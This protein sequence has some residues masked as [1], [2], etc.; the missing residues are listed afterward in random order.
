MHGFN[1]RVLG[2]KTREE[3]RTDQCQVAQQERDPSD[4]HVFTHTTH[5]AN[6]LVVV[7]T[8]DHRASPEEQQRFE[9]RVCHQVE[10]GYGVGRHTQRNRHITQLR[11]RGV[12][13]HALDVVLDDAQ[14][15]HEQ[16][17]DGTDHQNEVQCHIRQFIQGRHARHHK[18]TRRH[19]GRRVDQCGDR[20]GAFHGIWQPSMQRELRRLTHGTNEQA[21]GGHRD[22]RP[23]GARQSLRGKFW[24]LGKD[25]SVVQRAGIGSNQANTQDETKVTYTVDQECLHVGKRGR[26]LLVIEANQQVRHQA[27]R[28]PA[29]EQLQQVVTHHQHQHGEGKQGDVREE[30]V[31]TVIFFH[32]THRVDM[33]HQ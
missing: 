31:V 9:E 22:Q 15:T 3:R 6:V 19:H 32:I 17:R 12:R 14:D 21:N 29:K 20:C 26:G 16:G 30:T 11:Q 8:H 10:R 25:F 23:I 4:G 18:D 5:P 33:H 28:F 2:V 27:H 24:Q 13:N 1:D 7:H